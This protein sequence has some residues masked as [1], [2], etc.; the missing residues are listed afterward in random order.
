MVSHL[1]K[2]RKFSIGERLVPDHNKKLGPNFVPRGYMIINHRRVLED[3]IDSNLREVILF[4]PQFKVSK[5][6]KIFVYRLPN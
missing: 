3:N 5:E 6:T 2:S 4:T 1:I